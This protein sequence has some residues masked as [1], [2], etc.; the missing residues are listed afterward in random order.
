ML[1]P[2]NFY[3]EGF[4]Q[5]P[6]V[7]LK[8]E[9]LHC[10]ATGSASQDDPSIGINISQRPAMLDYQKVHYAGNKLHLAKCT[11][12][13]SREWKVLFRNSEWQSP[14]GVECVHTARGVIYLPFIQ[15]QL[16]YVP[17]WVASTQRT[18]FSAPECTTFGASEVWC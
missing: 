4:I 11:L 1:I 5:R 13:R 10:G 16:I 18:S 2:L 17:Q 14:L 8:I 7:H 3:S 6:S 15:I 9:T 12:N